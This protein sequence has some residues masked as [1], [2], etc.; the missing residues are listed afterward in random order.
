MMFGK[1][2]PDPRDRFSGKKTI[3]ATCV[4]LTIALGGCASTT[5]AAKPAA[6]TPPP[7]PS[8]MPRVSGPAQDSTVLQTHIWRHQ[9]HAFPVL[10]A[11]LPES[12]HAIAITNDFL[13]ASLRQRQRCGGGGE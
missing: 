11:V 9:V 4:A 1:L 10:D 12:A 6:E 2:R 3:A 13:R 5:P 8:S 7:A